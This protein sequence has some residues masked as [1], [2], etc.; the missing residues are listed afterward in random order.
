M[1][2]A[3][4][5]FRREEQKQGANN[6]HNTMPG[7]FDEIRKEEE[8]RKAGETFWTDGQPII[9]LLQLNMNQLQSY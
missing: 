2:L 4:Q 9:G 7:L 6:I 5:Q 8:G 1:Y 3:S